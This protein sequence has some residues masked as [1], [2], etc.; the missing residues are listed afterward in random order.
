MDLLAL[1]VILGGLGTINP[2]QDANLQYQASI[3][4]TAPLVENLFHKRMKH[5]TMPLLAH[6]P[7]ADSYR[8]LELKQIYKQHENDKKRLY[9]QRVMDVEQGTFTP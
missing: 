2:S 7:N 9:T 1:P 4:T 6:Y 3:K 8:D 5:L